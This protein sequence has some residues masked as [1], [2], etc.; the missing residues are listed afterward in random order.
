MPAATLNLNLEK[1]TTF[2]PVQIT[3]K[4]ASGAI[5]PLAGWSAFAEVRKEGKGYLILDLGPV[6]EADDAAGLVT[7][8]EVPWSE[9]EDLPVVEA[10]W[11]L[12]LQDPS[13]RRLPPLLGGKFDITRPV[14]QPVV[15]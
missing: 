5:V 12:I 3:C 1:G 11:D 4:N 7:L 2:G 9:T 8:R 10:L 14:T 6:I 13:G 15:P